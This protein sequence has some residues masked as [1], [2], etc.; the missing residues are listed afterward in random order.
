MTHP[1]RLELGSDLRQAVADSTAS[2]LGGVQ[3]VTTTQT[4]DG[5]NF[6]VR[7]EVPE[8]QTSTT[9]SSFG[10][11]NLTAL[12]ETLDDGAAPRTVTARLVNTPIVVQRLGTSASCCV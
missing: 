12:L 11:A 6:Q 4:L 8:G 10:R 2:G 5:T 3:V 7:V 1:D 9:V